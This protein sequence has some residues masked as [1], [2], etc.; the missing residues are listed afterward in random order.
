MTIYSTRQSA[1]KLRTPDG[2]AQQVRRMLRDSR[3]SALIQNFAAQW[4]HLNNLSDVVGD[5]VNFPDFDDNLVEAFRSETELFIRSTIA[6]NRSVL[7]LL[8]ADYT[9]VNERLA[10]HYG[11]SGI[12]GSRFRRITLPDPQQRGGIL[13]N[14]SV[15]A[16]TSY[17]TRTSPVLRGKWLLDTLLGAPPPSPPQNIPELPLRGDNGRV[18]SVRQRLE[19]HR[20]NPACAACH[21]TIDPLGF[22]LDNF[23]ALGAWRTVDEAGTPIDANGVMPGGVRVEGLSGL[24]ELLLSRPGQFA[25]T[26]TEK[27]LAYALGRALDHRDRPT[28]RKIVR[29]ARNDDYRWSSLILGVVESPAFRMRRSGTDITRSAR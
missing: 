11:L 12:Y 15:L 2:M 3:A 1:R 20:K 26:V 9:Y 25:G 17:P 23:D 7:D 21:S 14:G 13:G 5:P 6:E 28:V 29:D 22:A 8:R 24:R 18:A 16:L 10:R 27:L 19:Q 4:L